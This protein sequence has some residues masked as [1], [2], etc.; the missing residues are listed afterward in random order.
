M[1]LFGREPQFFLPQGVLVYVRYTGTEPRGL[2]GESIYTRRE[3]FNGG[4]AQ[5]VEGYW[6]VFVQEMR[7]EAVFAA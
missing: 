5:V 2:P 3:N 4:P 7:G 6:V 1:L